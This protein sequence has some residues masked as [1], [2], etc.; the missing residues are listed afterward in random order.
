MIEKRTIVDQRE[1][2]RDGTI[3]VRF[4]KEI[5]EDGV[6]ISFGY[7]RVALQ[8]GDDLDNA[9]ASVN[10]HLQFMKN[11]SVSSD[12]ID[13]IRRIVTAEH[14]VEKISEFQAAKEALLSADE[15]K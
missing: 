3:Q 13:S 5:I 8:P 11:E 15:V 6:V 4:R 7:H 14:T 10:N 1:V 9:M 12:E 2:M